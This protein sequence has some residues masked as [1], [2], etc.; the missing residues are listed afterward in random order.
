M[1]SKLHLCKLRLGDLDKVIE[2]ER[3][4]HT[5]SGRELGRLAW[6]WCVG[7]QLNELVNQHINSIPMCQHVDHNLEAILVG[8]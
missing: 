7:L 2:G 8:Q 6:E 4:M 1:S 5:H 3:G